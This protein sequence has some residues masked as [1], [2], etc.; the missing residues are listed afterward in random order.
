MTPDISREGLTPTKI[1]HTLK[2]LTLKKS[3]NAMIFV[4]HFSDID[5]DTLIKKWKKWMILDIDDCIAPHHGNILDKNHQIIEW[6]IKKGWKIVIFS[7]MKKTPRYDTL[8][9]LWIHIIT[10]PYAK[11][12]PRWFTECLEILHLNAG[13]VVMVGDNFLTDWGSLSVWIDF[14]KVKP[15]N[16]DT[17]KKSISRKLQILMREMVDTIADIRHKQ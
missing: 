17:W 13:Q 7:N 15:I 8:E 14:I 16:G 10:S 5:F 11:P 1:S 12:D 4:N 2:V 3:T 9:K 6:L